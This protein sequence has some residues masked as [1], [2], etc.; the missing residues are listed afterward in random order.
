MVLAILIQRCV[1]LPRDWVGSVLNWK[2]I[3]FVGALSYSLYLWQ[4]LFLNRESSA[5]VN[6]FTQNLVFA[7]AVAL[8]SYFFLK[9]PCSSCAIACKPK[10]LFRSLAKESC[11]MVR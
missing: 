2:P 6:S 11:E 9:N 4:Q 1:Y 8:A 10:V 7:I 3:V 5:W